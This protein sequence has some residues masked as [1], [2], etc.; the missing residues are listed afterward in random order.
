M[1]FAN[2]LSV[3]LISFIFCVQSAIAAPEKKL[4]PQWQES[5]ENS[6]VVVDHSAWQ[7]ALDAYLSMDNGQALFNYRQVDAK[8]KK[9]IEAYIQSLVS[10]NP[11]LLNRKEQK[12]YWMNLYNSVTINIVLDEYPVKSITKIGKGLFSF[13]PW[14]Q[15][16]IM[17]RVFI[18]ESIVPVLVA[19][20]Y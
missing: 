2:T 19:R 9:N 11:L 4:L 17:I 15:K 10:I 14:K 8:G 7:K 3:I 6:T 1:S 18:T 16:Y 12:A 13:G 5:N 20:T